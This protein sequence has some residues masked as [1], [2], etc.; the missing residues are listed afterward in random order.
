MIVPIYVD[1]DGQLGRLGAARMIGNST[2]T[3]LQMKLP[4]KPERVLINA[5]HD[6][7]SQP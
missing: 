7:L 4:K 6:V 2:S 5:Y 1:F 3:D